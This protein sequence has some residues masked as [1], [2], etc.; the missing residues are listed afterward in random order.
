MKMNRQPDQH[1]ISIA[2]KKSDWEKN[3][4]GQKKLSD[5]FQILKS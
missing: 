3:K 1:L 2:K 5:I 4:F